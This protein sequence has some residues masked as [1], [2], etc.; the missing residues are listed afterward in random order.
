[1]L[2]KPIWGKI[3]VTYSQKNYNYAHWN[4]LSFILPLAMHE[5]WHF[6]RLYQDLVLSDLSISDNFNGLKIVAYRCCS[7]NLDDFLCI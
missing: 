3:P 7:A 5:G 6:P 1:M 4:S 2:I